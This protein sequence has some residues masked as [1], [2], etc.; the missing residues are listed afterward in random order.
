MK[1]IRYLLT[2]PLSLI[3][4]LL[5]TFFLVIALLAPFL[6]APKA[7]QSS[8]F[9]IPQKGFWA[10][11]KPPSEDAP[12]G[13]TQNQYDIYYG[14]IWG[15]RTAFK[16]GF[17]VVAS[18]TLI[19]IIVGSIAGLYGGMVDEVIMR[20]VDVFLSIPFLIGAMVLTTILGKGLVTMIIAL[21]TFGWMS[22]ARIIRSE[23][24]HV[25]EEEYVEAA[26]AIGSGIFR[27]SIKHVLP[28]SIYP[29][30]VQST[31]MTG[32]MV[33]TASALSFLGVGT[34]TG[35]ADWG[36]LISFA[37]NWILGQGQNPFHYWYTIFFPGLAIVLFV[38]AWNLVGD[39][40][41]DIMD[42][43]LYRE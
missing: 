27:L 23:I 29:V 6:A 24:L 34:E 41:R 15:T 9:Q 14:V 26:R 20:M 35:Y 1:T 7:Y 13:T 5:L 18:A 31:M 38:L 25:R 33:L 2:N 36:Q 39:A 16:I 37:R 8:P 43:R 32:S 28:N 22:Y 30:L 12:F 19:G 10:E 40:L 17:G 3:G 4:L 42:P 21:T 11:P